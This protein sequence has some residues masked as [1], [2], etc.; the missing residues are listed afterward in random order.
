LQELITVYLS[1]G[2]KDH[3]RSHYCALIKSEKIENSLATLTWDLFYG[4]GNPGAVQYYENGKPR[5]DY[6]RFGNDHGVE[7]L[8]I[9]LGILHHSGRSFRSIP[10]GYFARLR[11]AIS[12]HSGPPCR[13]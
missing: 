8:I 3:T 2:G 12:E 7:P 5:V 9:G 4:Q 13:G 1:D 6:L 11:P 10:A